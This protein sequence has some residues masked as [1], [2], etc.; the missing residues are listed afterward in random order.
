MKT[1]A[2]NP[3]FARVRSPRR[4]AKQR[5]FTLLEILLA[6]ALVSLVLVGVNT[7]VFSMGELW[8]R[9]ADV[10]LFDRHTR[11]VTR[12]LERELRAAALP[13]A[14]RADAAPIGLQEIRPQNGMMENLLTFDLP[15]GSRF[16]TWPDRPLPEVVC[17]FQVRP[18]EGLVLLWHSRLEKNFE[19]EPP[20]ESVI[21]PF[22]TA[23]AYDYYEEETKRWTSER[24]LK[25]DAQSK[26]VTPQRLRLTFTYGK[27]TRETVVTLPTPGQALPTF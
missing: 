16:F 19:S 25:T 22:V 17:S 12:F 8:G 13:P 20:R 14:G 5:G 4:A 27:L 10:R 6:L 3:R 2:E 23:I 21:T 26:P 15:G 18:N 24:M 9:N 1:P 7:F 11:S